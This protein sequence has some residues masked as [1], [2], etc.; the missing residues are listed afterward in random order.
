M[1]CDVIVRR[2]SAASSRIACTRVAGKFTCKSMVSPVEAAYARF[3]GAP[4]PLIDVPFVR[5]FCA[6]MLVMRNS[7][8]LIT[9]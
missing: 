1:T 4:V 7:V 2:S 8:P 5:G 6:G 9:K 3:F